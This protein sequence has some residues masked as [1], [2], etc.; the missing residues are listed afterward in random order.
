M[1]LPSFISVVSKAMLKIQ[2]WKAGQV[3]KAI[4][5]QAIEKIF[6]KHLKKQS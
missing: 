4:F 2:H 5:M 6:Y 3:N 1:D